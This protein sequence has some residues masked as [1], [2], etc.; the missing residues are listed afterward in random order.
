MQSNH[1][2]RREKNP[3]LSMHLIRH[4]DEIFSIYFIL[5]FYH[6]KYRVYNNELYQHA[7]ISAI[8]I[9]CHSISVKNTNLMNTKS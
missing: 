6:Q 5:G 8:V 1:R 2:M 9:L 3:L 4:V 7:F